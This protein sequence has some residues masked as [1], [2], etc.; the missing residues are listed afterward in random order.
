MSGTE[1]Q[2]GGARCGTWRRRA[3]HGWRSP[4][5]AASRRSSACSSR[6]ADRRRL[7][8]LRSRASRGNPCRSPSQRA[9]ASCRSST[10]PH[11]EWRRRKSA[12][13]GKGARQSNESPVAT[14]Q[15][16]AARRGRPVPA[17]RAPH[18][19]DWNPSRAPPQ[20]P[21]RPACPLLPPHP[22][23]PRRHS[24]ELRTRPPRAGAAI[25]AAGGIPPLVA[26]SRRRP[27]AYQRLRHALEH[28][29]RTA[30]GGAHARLHQRI[31]LRPTICCS[32]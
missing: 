25:A 30:R 19:T 29:A 23:Q 14:L 3:S 10:D 20:R 9:A 13:G 24:I 2:G 28:L 16:T 1:A 26:L 6:T 22:T 31:G 7:R 5:A 4:R 17:N 32:R 8:P 11:D 12:A 21:C 18:Q 15:A 27:W